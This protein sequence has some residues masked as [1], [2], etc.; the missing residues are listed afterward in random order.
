MGPQAKFVQILKLLAIAAK[1]CPIF[2]RKHA[3]AQI[4]HEYCNKTEKRQKKMR[5]VPTRTCTPIG[6]T[7][8]GQKWKKGQKG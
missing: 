8:K 1:K 6:C 7:K 3:N 2:T 5:I 4:F